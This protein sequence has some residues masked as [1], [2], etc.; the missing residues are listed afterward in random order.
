[1]TE[2]LKGER[3]WFWY[4]E[5]KAGIRDELEIKKELRQNWL[6]GNTEKSWQNY[7]TQR[8]KV[9]SLKRISTK[10]YLEDKTTNFPEHLSKHEHRNA[11]KVLK[12]V[13]NEKCRFPKRFKNFVQ[14]KFV[15]C[16]SKK[17]SR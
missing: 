17:S 13:L 2:N 9:I 14:T 15:D 4:E 6:V 12:E 1:M 11:F 5:M 16:Y 10:N 3:K 7:K 8:N